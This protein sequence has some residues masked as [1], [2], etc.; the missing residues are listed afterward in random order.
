MDTK[1]IDIW[2]KLYVAAEQLKH[3]QLWNC[4]CSDDPIVIRLDQPE[5]SLFC[6]VLGHEGDCFGISVYVGDTGLSDYIRILHADELPDSSCLMFRQSGLTLYWG[7]RDE[8]PKDQKAIIKELGLRFRGSGNW[9]FAFSLR[10]RCV[11]CTP[12]AEELQLLVKAL[13]NLVMVARGFREGRL[14]PQWD[15]TN[16][17][18]R[19]YDE[20]D[21]L[22]KMGWL[23][24]ELPEPKYPQ[25]FITDE[26]LLARLKKRP[27]TQAEIVADF[28]DLNGMS[29]G[30][31]DGRDAILTVFIMAD[32]A[33]GMIVSMEGISPEVDEGHAALDAV[34]SY[35]KE[36]GRMKAIRV[37]NPWVFHALTRTCKSCK[38]PLYYDDLP[39]IDEIAEQLLENMLFRR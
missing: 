14:T 18:M 23:P 28:V 39:E 16:A 9:P 24:L 31:I 30:Q 34:V 5:T 7:D 33:T 1:T 20:D 17:L 35:I 36:H 29:C 12:D 8:V 2:Q 4:V 3:I 15:G 32:T 19:F 21:R 38:I 37:R 13:Q 11:P 25:V 6:S 27:H 26:L 22:W 10:P